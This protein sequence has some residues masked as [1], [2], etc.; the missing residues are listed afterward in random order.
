MQNNQQNF[1]PTNFQQEAFAV[2]AVV[3]GAMAVVAVDTLVVAIAV[4]AVEEEVAVVAATVEVEVDIE[5]DN[6]DEVVLAFEEQEEY[7]EVA[8]VEF[9]DGIGIVEVVVLVYYRSNLVVVEE[10]SQQEADKIAVGYTWDEEVE[11]VAQEIEEQEHREIAVD[12]V[13][14]VDGMQ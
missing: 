13:E 4:V 2:V 12:V 1:N 10:D 14:V 3:V 11:Y 7:I 5:V 8:E 9:D 6:L